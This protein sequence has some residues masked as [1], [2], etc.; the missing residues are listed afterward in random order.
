MVHGIDRVDI[1]AI[2]GGGGTR[3]IDPA[4]ATMTF[5]TFG[6]CEPDCPCSCRAGHRLLMAVAH[7]AGFQR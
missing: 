6:E 3:S 5:S 2:N 4:T 1:A 7:L